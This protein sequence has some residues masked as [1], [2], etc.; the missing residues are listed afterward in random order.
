MLDAGVN[1]DTR[2]FEELCRAHI[3]AF[4]RGAEKYAAETRLSARV[5]LWQG[6]LMPLLDEED[7]RPVFDIHLYGNAV[8]EKMESQIEK[9]GQTGER[10]LKPSKV[11]AF[12]DIARDCQPFDVCRMFLATLSLNNSGNVQFTDDSTLDALQ[13]ELVTSDIE[14]PMESYL[15]AIAA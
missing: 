3:A 15:S 8:I 14:V 11:V 9:M 6:K 13:V 5:G 4:A 10:T 7:R 12:R 1:E 2:T